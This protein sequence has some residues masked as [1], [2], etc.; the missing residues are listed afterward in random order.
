MAGSRHYRFT[1]NGSNH[2]DHSVVIRSDYH[3]LGQSNL[4]CAL[5]NVLDQ[6]FA[7]DIDQGFAG[8]PGGAVSSRDD[9]YCLHGHQ[10]SNQ[11]CEES[12][13]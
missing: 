5:H 7:K 12:R 13:G 2:F 3:T 9:D 1:A 4:I 10:D 8:Q 11:V 6:G